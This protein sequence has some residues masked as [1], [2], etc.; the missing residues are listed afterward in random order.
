M[1]TKCD[2]STTPDEKVF[3][4]VHQMDTLFTYKGDESCK[5]QFTM[6]VK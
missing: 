3:N 5:L 6:V 1:R 2:Y 4:E